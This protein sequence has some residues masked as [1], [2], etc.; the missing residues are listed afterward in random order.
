MDVEDKV[1]RTLRTFGALFRS[2]FHDGIV[3][4]YN[5]F[6]AENVGKQVRCHT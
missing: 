3:Y 5:N 4:N 1:A 6:G 2:V